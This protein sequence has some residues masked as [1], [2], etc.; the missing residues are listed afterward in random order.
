MRNLKRALS[1]A[2]ASIMLLGMMVTGAGA[3]STSFTDF[4]SIVNQEAAEVTSGLKIF[5][6]YTDGSFGPERPV[7]RAEMAVIICKLLNGSDVDPGNFTGI[8]KFTDVPS[9]AEGYV[10]Y[11]NSMGIVVG[12]GDGKFDPNRTVS[13]VEAATML[14]KALGYFIEEDQ[15]GADWKTVVTGRA[16][17]LHLYGELTLSVDEALTRDNVAELV[18]HTLFAQRVAYDDNRHLYVKNTDRDVVVTNGTDDKDNTFAMNTFGMWYVDGIVTANSYT[19]DSLSETTNNKPRTM[20]WFEGSNVNLGDGPVAQY[21]FEYTTGLDMIGHAARTYYSIEKRAPVVYAIV[22]RA[23]KTEYITYDSNTTRLADA[24]NEAGFRKN[25][26][27]LTDS[28]DYLVNYDW[29]VTVKD[30]ANT[31]KNVVLNGPDVAKTL[32]LISNSSDY[33]V[34]YVIVL[35]QY[36]D[37]VRRVVDKNT[38]MKYDLTS[39]NGSKQ[40][41]T[42]EEL[43]EKDYVVV[44]DI[45]KQGE[46]FNLY[47]PETAAANITKITGVSDG[48]G[49]VKSILADGTEYKGSPV[50]IYGGNRVENLENTTDFEDIATIGESTLILDFQGKVIGLG[51]PEKVT[52]YAYAAQFGVWHTGGSLNTEYKLT[53]KL[54]FIDGTS[55]VYLVNTGDSKNINTFYKLKM[56][57]AGGATS[58]AQAENTA[59]ILNT[60]STTGTY[61]PKLTY[62]DTISV[63]EATGALQNSTNGGLGVYKV[64][65]RADD[66]VVMTALKSDMA[67]QVD[68]GTRLVPGHSTLVKNNGSN[69]T[70]TFPGSP[71]FYQTNKTVYFYVD[72]SYTADTLSVGTRTGVTNAKGITHDT[73]DHDENLVKETFEQIFVTDVPGANS[74]DTVE[75]VMIY[76]L[77][78]GAN[79]DLY[80]YRHGN[81]HITTRANAPASSRASDNDLVITYDLYTAAGEVYSKTYDNDG[82]GYDMDTAKNTVESKPTGW[83]EIGSKDL[84]DKYVLDNN[85]DVDKIKFNPAS[86]NRNDKTKNVYVLNAQ[87]EHDEFVK[88]IYTRVDNVGGIILDNALVVDACNSGLDSVSDIASAC[89]ANHLVRISYTYKVTGDDAFK[90]STVFVT[91]YDPAENSKPSVSHDGLYTVYNP[92]TGGLDVFDDVKNPATSEQL[93]AAAKAAFEGAGFTVTNVYPEGLGNKAWVMTIA[94]DG[95]TQYVTNKQGGGS[96]GYFTYMDRVREMVKINVNGVFSGYYPTPDDGTNIAATLKAAANTSIIKGSAKTLFATTNAAGEFKYPA[97]SADK[98]VTIDFGEAVKVDTITGVTVDYQATATKREPVYAGDYVPMGTE[99][100]IT[101]AG[102]ATGKAIVVARGDKTDVTGEVGVGTLEYVATKGDVLKITAG[103][104]VKLVV[105]TGMTVKYMPSG[106]SAEADIVTVNAGS[107]AV[108]SG[109]TLKEINGESTTGSA[110]LVQP[111]AVGDPV[112]ASELVA[113]A[114]SVTISSYSNV[115]KDTYI[116][117][118]QQ[119]E[120]VKTAATSTTVAADKLTATI[121]AQF[122]SDTEADITTNYYVAVGTTV[123]VE[124]IGTSEGLY[125][126]VDGVKTGT[127]ADN[128]NVGKGSFVVTAKATGK[129]VLDTGRTERP[130]EVTIPGTNDPS[131][132]EGESLKDKLIA[133]GIK[134]EDAENAVRN[135]DLIFLWVRTEAGSGAVTVTPGAGNAADAKETSTYNFTWDKPNPDAAIIIGTTHDYQT[136]NSGSPYPAGT[137][138]YTL[139]FNGSVVASGNFTTG[140]DGKVTDINSNN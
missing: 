122:A 80:F 1:L 126:T 104:Y 40:N 54:H 6:G 32:L 71:A 62:L 17:S 49:T 85:S 55:G 20:V 133:S 108:A 29:N 107:Y 21:A 87:A 115:S 140:A 52:N 100:T 26:V 24:A 92:L 38:L 36:L 131:G 18:F 64:S 121:P 139:T 98:G 16:T 82:K 118:P 22:D 7:T 39:G 88:N 50:A 47:K 106:K 70:S 4:D 27:L 69:V 42:L 59:K 117:A 76:G 61:N 66:T 119:I 37:T 72:G 63:D 65:V 110:I 79:T 9:W 78:L 134:P 34:D 56:S 14:L 123:N 41:I 60:G 73:S 15:L 46:M 138:N 86:T 129:I 8:S 13:T 101:I 74:R 3:A 19:D 109:W 10:N 103:N 77:D 95:M 84:K 91:G 44:T 105:G 5:E 43:A 28:G 96:F 45:G 89:K 120:I 25:S 124:T 113:S 90:V 31:S 136:S 57:A 51:E 83:Y 75:A 30:L 33:K 125:V 99:L 137:W 93:A 67:N 111:S 127:E 130:P 94:K 53:V 135:G 58:A 48:R 23:T 2:L 68:V 112:K 81:Y 116:Y 102:D 11:C 132:G 128:V 35:D 12:V 97:T 114:V